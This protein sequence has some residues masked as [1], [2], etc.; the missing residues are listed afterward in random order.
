M[1]DGP[2]GAE[3]LGGVVERLAP[4]DDAAFGQLVDAVDDELNEE[5]TEKQRRD[6]EDH[7]HVQPAAPV[8]PAPG[9]EA[10]GD[11][12]QDRPGGHEQGLGPFLGGPQRHRLH[13]QVEHGLEPFARHQERGHE[14]DAGQRPQRRRCPFRPATWPT[15]VSI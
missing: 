15:R 11:E 8:R 2:V 9:D 4:L 7:A 10:R 14:G 13:P 1:A 3:Q 12:P 6:L 5:E